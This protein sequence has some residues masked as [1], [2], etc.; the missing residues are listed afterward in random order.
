MIS[1]VVLIVGYRNSPDIV[2]CLRALAAAGS[3]P[4]FDVFI[5]ENGSAAGMDALIARLDAGDSAWRR[6][7][8]AAPPTRPRNARRICD[9]R[10]VRPNGG[11][12]AFVHL[13][14]MDENLGYAGG[15]NAWLRPLLA[16]PGWDAAWLLN[17]DTQPEPDALA[18]LASYAASHAKGMVG[19]CIIYS[20]RLDTVSTR[21]LEWKKLASRVLA[22]DRGVKL[23]IEPDASRVE[24]PTYRTVG[25][26]GLRHASRHRCDR[27]HGRALF[28]LCRGPGMGWA[29][30]TFTDG[31]LCTPVSCFA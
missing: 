4:S 3:G 30:A 10:L 14:E 13:A 23:A 19:S 26:F 22:I 2:D 15:V 18:E 31:R 11:A 8:A 5:A 17:P 27:A 28:S 9:Y 29:G 6:S 7:D 25:G 21:G 16:V 12:G 1:V 24:V 20:D